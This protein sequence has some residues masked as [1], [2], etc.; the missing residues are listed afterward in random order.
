MNYLIAIGLFTFSTAAYAHVTIDPKTATAGDYA[1]VVFRVSHGCDMS[2]TTAITVK[3]PE[4]VLAAK[5]QVKSGWKITIKKAKLAKPSMMHGKEIPEA[6]SE[7]TWSGGDLSG[8]HMD[9]FGLSFKSPD[10]AGDLFFAVLQTCKKGSA[11]WAEA[12]MPAEH[13]NHATPMNSFPA[14]VLHLVEKSAK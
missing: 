7:I 13:M 4:G 14:P 9:E 10:V 2:P 3:I 12:A 5:P 1:K 8:E 11:N 6:A